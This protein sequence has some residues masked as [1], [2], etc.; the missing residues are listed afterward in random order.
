MKNMVM[1]YYGLT[2]LNSYREKNKFIFRNNDG[3][4]VLEPINN[5]ER[6]FSVYR[7]LLNDKR[8][9]KILTNINSSIFTNIYGVDYVLLK[10]SEDYYDLSKEILKYNIVEN[11]SL[12]D[13]PDWAVLWESKLDYYEYQIAHISGNYPL[14]DESLSYFIGMGENAISYFRYNVINVDEPIVISHRRIDKEDFFNPL[15]VVFDYRSRDIS[16][17]LKYLFFNKDIDD[18][19]FHAFFKKLKFDRNEF[20]LLFSRMLFPSFY[21]DL[22]D[23]VVNKNEDQKILVDVIKKVGD[24]ERFLITIYNHINGI[25]EIPKVDWL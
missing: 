12:L 11:S 13:K 1:Y 25:V 4:F 17:Y 19:D 14:I 23:A 15:N 18:F 20:I 9:F 7:F 6:V 8:Y 2:N 5:R 16:E 22:Y 21:F 24:Y 10:R 3:I